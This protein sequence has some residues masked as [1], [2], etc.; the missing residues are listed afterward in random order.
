M[1]HLILHPQTKAELLALYQDP[2]QALLLVAPTGSGKLAV[3][4][5]WGATIA[6][7]D[8]ISVLAPDE[9]GTI[10]I[11]A[12]RNLYRATRAKRSERQVVIIDHAEAMGV[13]A[14][15]AFLKLLEEPRA[16]LT[17]VLS[18]PTVESL[19]P[20]IVSRV[21]AVHVQP[22]GTAIL[23]AHAK[24]A[25]PSIDAQT[26]QQLLFVA[27]GRPA[28]LITMLGDD[29]AF[30][31]HKTIMGTA[32]KLLAATSYERLAMV[33]AITKDRSELTLTLEAMAHMLRLQLAHDP[34][35]QWTRL[36]DALQEC[37]QRLRENGNMRAQVTHLFLQY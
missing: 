9:K 34:K 28:A 33:G 30:T 5:A 18:A 2:P 35:P 10:T 11:E 32:K 37:L 21:Q 1:E 31:Y 12:T 14:Q 7:A 6:P 29:T 26:L 3:A 36:A 8:A 20:T 22:V 4:E 15:N 24:K 23:A 13:E 19:L 25:R 17:F 16:N 27:A